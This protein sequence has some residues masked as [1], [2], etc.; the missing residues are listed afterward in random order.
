MLLR[1]ES[2][3]KIRES[4]DPI[5]ESYARLAQGLIGEIAGTCLLDG[6][7]RVLGSNGHI[8]LAGIRPWIDELGWNGTLAR[9]PAAR[10]L[11]ANQLVIAIPLEQSDTTL[12]GIFCVQQPVTSQ[13]GNTGRHAA[14]LG[15]RLKPLLDCIYRDLE[16]RVPVRARVQAMTDRTAELEWLFKVVSRTRGGGDDRH[17]IRELL[18]AATLRLDASMGICAIPDKRILVEFMPEAVAGSQE[19]GWHSPR[20]L[21]G[22]W[23]QASM[24]IINWTQ[25]RRTPL[26][27]NSA[28]RDGATM[29]RCKV[30]AVPVMRDSGKVIGALTFIN[31]PFAADFSSRQVY[32]AKHLGLQAANVVDMQFDLMTGLYTQGALEPIHAAIEAEAGG[33]P[34]A[35]IY[36]DID[37]MHVVNQTHGFEIGNELIVRVADLMAPPLLPAT[38]LAA[39]VYGDRFA[40]VLPAF[41]AR[42]AQGI[43]LALQQAIRDLQIGALD[44]PVEVSSSCGVADIVPMPQGLERSLGAAEIACKTAKSRGGN[45]VELYA[46]DDRSMMRRQ[47]DALAVG[48]LRAAL[49][50]DRL[51]LFAQRIKPVRDPS[52]PGG[53]E[54]LVRLPDEAGERVPLDS[55]MR[56][57]Q[58][59]SL[60]PSLDRW[61]TQRALQLLAPHATMLQT[62]AIEFL[63]P[64]ASQSFADAAFVGKLSELLRA[65]ALPQGCITLQFTEQAATEALVHAKALTRRMKQYGCRYAFDEFSMGRDSALQIGNLEVTRLR[66]PVKAGVAAIRSMVEFSRIVAAEI[67]VTGVDTEALSA[68]LHRSGVDYLQGAAIGEPEPLEDLLRDLGCDESR[69]QERLRLELG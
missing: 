25:R 45:R 11:A 8:L 50:A 35:L 16:A 14:E 47:D 39:R 21:R 60:L 32:L 53:Y 6:E 27:V 36:L 23:T 65:A 42:A 61:V 58:R 15:R 68:P 69:R 67:I 38:A 1:V 66:V 10:L 28:G 43:A 19:V 62:R 18:A 46:S 34:C 52:L 17:A 7:R 55:V 9:L 30:L 51:M 26:V 4:A 24:S 3:A 22:V 44:N 33:A 54:V 57:A 12:I 63:V 41:D 64:V 2:P 20:A 49:K 13:P 37:H 5:F 40:V 59:Y 56:A 29:P 48:R 31:P